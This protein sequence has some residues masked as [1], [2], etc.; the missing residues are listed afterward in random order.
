LKRIWEF[1]GREAATGTTVAIMGKPDHPENR[2]TLSRAL[3][4]GNA[5]VQLADLAAVARFAGFIQL[6]TRNSQ[7]ETAL[8]I[9]IHNQDRLNL[10]SLAFAAQTTLLYSETAE[11]ER[12]L[13]AAAE[14]AGA[15]FA[16]A[17]TVCLATQ[18]RQKA[19]LDLCAEGCDLFLVVG[20]FASSNTA[21]LYRLASQHAPAYFIRTAADFDAARITHFDPAAKEVKVTEG[22]LPAAGAAIGLLSGA[23]CPAGDIGGVIRKLR[24]LAESA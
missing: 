16:S 10:K 21:Q 19:A 18:E 8:G 7:L 5:V 20:G 24:M 12:L 6:A 9:T 17:A 2:A 13:R 1:V 15:R 4:E 22:W 11:A 23:S 3:T 14:S